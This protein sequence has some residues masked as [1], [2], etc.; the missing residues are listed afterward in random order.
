MSG[1]GIWGNV[2]SRPGGSSDQELSD[3]LGSPESGRL[4][5]VIT[6][7]LCKRF[8]VNFANYGEDF[9]AEIVT[10]AWRHLTEPMLWA[11]VSRYR[12]WPTGLTMV[13][14]ELVKSLVESPEYLGSRGMSTTV[15]RQRALAMRA[16]ELRDELG[17]EPSAT[18]LVAYHNAQVSAFRSSAAR[19]GAL[20]SVSDLS[21]VRMVELDPTLELASGGHEDDCPLIPLEAR[22][23]VGL[24]L[25]RCEQMDPMVA[26]A[27][28]A[29]L[30]GYL[31]T[32]PYVGSV[33]DVVQATRL[34]LE[35]AHALIRGVQVVARQVLADTFG[36]ETDDRESASAPVA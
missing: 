19:Q 17:R 13:C 5:D 31:D 10:F 24:V 18:E 14:R 23:L 27:A 35:E 32:E 30:G 26:L 25:E 20:A 34:P 21:P 36:I 16:A 12:D 7:S 22:S 4:F 6:S 3:F 33:A 2:P 11:K 28:R 9:R 8:N 15:R 29:Y 1:W